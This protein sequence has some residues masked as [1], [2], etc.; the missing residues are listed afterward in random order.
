M[1]TIERLWCPGQPRWPWWPWCISL[2]HPAEI[3]TYHVITLTDG[4]PSATWPTPPRASRSPWGAAEAPVRAWVSMIGGARAAERARPA[5][6]AERELAQRTRLHR[7]H[8]CAEPRTSRAGRERG[9]ARGAKRSGTECCSISRG[10]PTRVRRPLAT[11]TL[12]KSNGTLWLGLVPSPAEASR[13]APP[14]SA[15]MKAEPR[16]LEDRA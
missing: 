9:Q 12:P 10:R 1:V 7:S 13:S 8:G 11:S 4:W 14:R 5:A 15:S 3:Q 2:N 16:R 6:R